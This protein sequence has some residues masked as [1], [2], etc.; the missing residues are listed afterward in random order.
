[1]NVSCKEGLANKGIR[2]YYAVLPDGAPQKGLYINERYQQLNKEESKA[3][4]SEE[5]SRLF[6]QRK[7]DAESVFG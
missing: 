6:A 4:L 1:M 2:V 5:G 3:L 7:V